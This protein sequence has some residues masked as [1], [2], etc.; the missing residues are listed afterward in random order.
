MLGVFFGVDGA[1]ICRC[2]KRL[3]PLLVKIVHVEKTRHLSAGQL[4]ALIIDAT[5]SPV[6]RPTRGQRKYYSGKKKQHTVK[7]EIRI[8]GDGRILN[9]SRTVPGSVHD[10][11]LL[12]EGKPL[13]GNAVILADSGYPGIDKLRKRA[14]T[15]VGKTKT[16]HLTADEK[17][18]NGALSRIRVRVEHVFRQLKIFKT[19]S[20]RYRNKGKRYNL[21]FQ[22][23]A[24]FVNMKNGFH[25][26]FS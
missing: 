3:E 23:I 21:R 19:L 1:T 5:E 6:E 25:A 18:Y 4:H 11:H 17:Q 10:F 16:R 24:G 20:E 9:V 2:I 7:T 22:I 15:P 12:K 13:P 14:C 26:A 8:N